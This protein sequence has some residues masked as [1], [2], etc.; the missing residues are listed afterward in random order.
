MVQETDAHDAAADNYNSG[1]AGNFTLHAGTDCRTLQDNYRTFIR[2]SI[3]AGLSQYRS[4]LAIHQAL[5]SWE[6]LYNEPT[7]FRAMLVS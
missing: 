4:E 1:V 5:F 3:Q 6:F 7:V 2:L